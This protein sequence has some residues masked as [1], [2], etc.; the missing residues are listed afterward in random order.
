ML[1]L[2]YTFSTPEI[3]NTLKS[4]KIMCMY[5]DLVNPIYHVHDNFICSRGPILAINL[6]IICYELN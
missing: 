3:M 6:I 5:Q 1:A 2:L 4:I